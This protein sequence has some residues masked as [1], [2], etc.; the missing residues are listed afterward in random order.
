MAL[1]SVVSSLDGI[2][3]ALHALY[4]EK[5]GKHIL[6]IDG[7]DD[8]PAVI[9][10]KNGHTNSKRERDEARAKLTAAEKKLK[11]LPEDFDAAEWE[12]LKTE[13]EARQADPE[14]KDVRKQVETAVAA[15]ERQMQTRHDA[16]IRAKDEIIAEKDTAIASIT[17]DLRTT[18]VGDGLTKA[19]V[20]AGVK[21]TLLKAAQRMFEGDVEIVEEDGK[22]VARMKTDLG[23]DELD[24]FI[25][26]WSQSDEAKDFI[27]PP[28]GAD[29]RGGNRNL[30]NG[31]TNP[32]A[33]ETWN[34][35]QQ[36]ALL[37]SDR[38]KAERL[39]KSAG[40]KDLNHANRSTGPLK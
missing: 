27:A 34:I 13:D 20:K 29:E 19:L 6:Q 37:G 22:R 33:K 5:D 39:A 4:E 40:F 31:E 12:R 15:K 7:I 30:R 14:G 1:K 38:A 36:G 10:L 16:A 32:Y 3:E 11:G 35:S 18:L 9:A 2:E 17:G 8:H 23:G 25:G 21:P 28:S 26:N 24:K